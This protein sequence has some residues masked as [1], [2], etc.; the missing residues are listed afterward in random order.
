MDP[1]IAT[2]LINLG[3]NLLKQA[4][5]ATAEVSPAT[6]ANFENNLL[7]HQHSNIAKIG[8]LDQLRSDL[9]KS[10]EVSEFLSR[11]TGNSIALDQLSDG[12]VRLL[13]SSGDFISLRPDTSTCRLA[14]QFFHSSIASG[15][16]IHP[17][18]V[19]SVILTG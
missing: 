19:N 6:E 14:N 18:R 8:D 10:P 17:Q 2:G 3:G 1:V 5:P 16:N 11:N 4:L 9:L 13:S 7:A 15:E 12:S